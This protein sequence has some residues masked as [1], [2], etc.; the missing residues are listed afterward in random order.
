[1]AAGRRAAAVAA[2]GRPATHRM[3]TAL[4]ERTIETIVLAAAAWPIVQSGVSTSFWRAFPHFARR[5]AALASVYLTLVVVTMIWGP[6]WLTRTM[7]IAAGVWL[8]ASSWHG[9]IARGR[10]KGWPPGALRILP[11]DAWFDRSFFFE[12]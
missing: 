12:Q 2:D 7:A 8:L 3:K 1:M 5:L 4:L 9:R 11:L 6:S 10:A